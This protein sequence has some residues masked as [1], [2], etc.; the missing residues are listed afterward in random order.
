LE[1]GEAAATPCSAA[2]QQQQQQ[3]DELPYLAMATQMFKAG[4]LPRGCQF[5]STLG[6]YHLNGR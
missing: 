3:Q 6:M 2:Q 4:L 1:D 5:N